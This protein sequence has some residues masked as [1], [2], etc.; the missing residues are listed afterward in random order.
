MTDPQTVDLS[1]RVAI[2]TGAGGGIGQAEA[3]AL[4]AAGAHV[5]VND[6]AHDQDGTA[7]AQRTVEEIVA[8]GGVASAN[9]SDISSFRGC[10]ELVDAA[11]NL[12]GRLDILV[13]NAAIYRV[14]HLE[15]ISDDEWEHVIR[16][17]LNGT[18]GTIRRAAPVFIAQRSGCIVNTGSGSGLGLAG[19]L[20]YSTSKE[21]I[22]GLT[23]S[24]ARELGQHGV[25]C[26]ALR[27]RATGTTM[28]RISDEVLVPWRALRAAQGRYANG[29]A[30]PDGVGRVVP[31]D[32]GPFVAWLSSDA[33]AHVNGRDF[34]IGGDLVGLVT[35][36]VV[37]RM[38]HRRGGWDLES[39]TLVGGPAVTAELENHFLPSAARSLRG[40]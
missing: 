18:F 24:V 25:R 28:S 2:V 33:A 32:V 31:D 29:N 30:W 20:A 3:R 7:W 8:A 26:N 5:V 13:N 10:D 15:H 9:T 16:V 38:A 17:N 14:G 11:V 21:A 1:G 6:I 27:P 12:Y 19:Q 40:D 37:G 23:R 36:P 22:I 39:V 4:A 35:E 34:L